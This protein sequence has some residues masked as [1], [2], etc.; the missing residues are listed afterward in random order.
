[1][2]IRTTPS[3]LHCSH[4]TSPQ[5]PQ[6]FT[7]HVCGPPR[8]QQAASTREAIVWHFSSR[9]L[10]FLLNPAALQERKTKSDS[11]AFQKVGAM[12]R[13]PVG[14]F[15]DP[16]K[17]AAVRQAGS[18]NRR[19]SRKGC[20]QSASCLEVIAQDQDLENDRSRQRCVIGCCTSDR[21]IAEQFQI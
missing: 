10:L 16:H 8:L 12:L 18:P 15:C 1:M 17:M 3:L 9:P 5:V 6:H 11:E 7:A 2:W 4:C 13:R 14:S 20:S 19:A 21:A